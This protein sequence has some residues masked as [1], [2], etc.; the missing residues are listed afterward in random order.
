MNHTMRIKTQFLISI[1]TF[2][3]ILVIIGASVAITQQQL[4]IY[5]SQEALAHDIQTGA[6][7]LNY[8]SNNYFL[9][10][11][12]SSIGLWQ[13]MFSSL[14]NKL[15]QLNSS[16][17]QQQVLIRKVGN[18]MINLSSVF[19]GVVS[20]LNSAPRN[21]SIRIL[22]SFQ[23]QWNRMAVQI[24]ALSFDSQQ[25]SQAIRNQTDQAIQTNTI[26]TVAF[27][28]VF[29]GYFITSYLIT[30]RRTL[31]SIAKLKNGIRVI[32]SGKLDYT[33]DAGKKDEIADISKAVNQMTIN[34]KT[35]TASKTD[36]EKEIKERKIATEALKESEERFSK[37][38]R[39]NPAAMAISSIDGTLI[40]VSD[41]YERLLGYTRE[42]VIGKR[43]ITL[44]LYAAPLERQELARQLQEKG[45]VSNYEISFRHKSGKAVRV[46]VSLERITLNGKPHFLGTAIDITERK[47]AEEALNQRN[48]ELERLQV[49]LEEK[50][51]EIEEYASKMESLAEERAKKLQDAERL[52]AIG[53]TA[54]MVGHDIRNPL[55]AMIGDVYLAKSD[56]DEIPEG[57]AKE[58]IRE[59]LDSI[60]K[61]VEY[62]NKIVADLQDFARPLTPTSRETSLEMIL[63]DI[64]VKKAIPDNVE[65]SREVN[66]DAKKLIGDPD[67]LKRIL[68]NLVNNAVQAMPKGGKLAIQAYRQE[69]DL[70][71]T[72][73]DTGVGISEGVR[74]KLFTPLF[75]TKSK[76]QGFGLAVVKRMTEALGGTITFE[77]ETGKGTKFIVRLPQKK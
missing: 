6:N 38:F 54:G 11:D 36:L 41:G 53:A 8:I 3:I 45:R 25:L 24:Q 9:Y 1:I 46:I 7:D 35:V 12:N 48:E 20:F 17:S 58:G 22:P 31:N 47:K 2:S 60:E 65:V 68:A 75:T 55:Q 51:A 18:D 4:D 56:V 26:L 73:G 59:S 63:D 72:V 10:Q 42:E 19:S 27:L 71:I 15:A 34:L 64:L 39:I 13:E 16:S 62:V 40:D 70:V 14:S 21:V 5:N 76:G 69:N 52:A 29:A 77:S 30:Y 44:G 50:A 33:I 37:A 74:P 57:T 23:S 61:N 67:L 32:G 66:A 43:V 49:N 28:G